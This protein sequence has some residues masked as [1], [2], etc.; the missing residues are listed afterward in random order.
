MV[1]FTLKAHTLKVN[2]SISFFPSSSTLFFSLLLLLL[3]P[4]TLYLCSCTFSAS[5]YYYY[6][7]SCSSNTI[8]LAFIIGLYL[9]VTFN[10][11]D[12]HYYYNVPYQTTTTNRKVYRLESVR[13]LFCKFYQYLRVTYKSL[14]FTQKLFLIL[15]RLFSL[16]IT[17]FRFIHF[18]TR[19]FL[20]RI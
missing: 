8:I 4:C 9:Y 12:I 19:T 7:L 10:S 17:M 1:S 16:S 20:L 2:C 5:S 13:S 11:L 14:F 6:S 18:F 3:S 15:H